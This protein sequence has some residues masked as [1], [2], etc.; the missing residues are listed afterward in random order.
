M[1]ISDDFGDFETGIDGI[2]VLALDNIS[3][4]EKQ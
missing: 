1:R 3:A 4:F 2:E